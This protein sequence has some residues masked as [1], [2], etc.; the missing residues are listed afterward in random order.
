MT[1]PAASV[2]IDGLNLYRRLL[3]GYPLD[4][5][6]DV[7]ALAQKLLPERS[8]ACGTS[9]RPSS[10]LPVK[11]LILRSASKSTSG[12]SEPFHT[13]QSTSASFVSTS[14]CWFCTQQS[15]TTQAVHEPSP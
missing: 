15:S 8:F 4:K 5:W 9:L 2:Y 13:P 10:P 12:P 1:R 6:L 11:I 3:Q 7:E 14:A